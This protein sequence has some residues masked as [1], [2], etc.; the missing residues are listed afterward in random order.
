MN[1]SPEQRIVNMLGN[2]KVPTLAT[3]NNEGALCM[4]LAESDVELPLTFLS[5]EELCGG[6]VQ[7]RCAVGENA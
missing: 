1:I 5:S 6:R 4:F 3:Q 2:N 7:L